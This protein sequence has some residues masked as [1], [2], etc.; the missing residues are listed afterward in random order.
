MRKSTTTPE[1]RSAAAVKAAATRKANKA[2]KA[3]A[4]QAPVLTASPSPEL[5]EAL[6][7]EQD[8]LTNAQAD[9]A[10]EI[11]TQ[12]EEADEFVPETGRSITD[13]EAAAVIKAAKIA[14]TFTGQGDPRTVYIAKG[15]YVVAGGEH[16]LRQIEGGT[17]VV[18]T[19]VD[20][21]VTAATIAKTWGPA[22]AVTQS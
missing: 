9:L 16:I 13:V 7:E 14:G 4:E 18:E 15:H 20:G 5:V 8:D 3:A 2:A 6:Q 17:W 10:A 1:Q 12:A 11:D 21:T 19:V 22:L